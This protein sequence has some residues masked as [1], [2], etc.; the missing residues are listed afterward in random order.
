M[1]ARAASEGE[2]TSESLAHFRLARALVAAGDDRVR[3]IG[4]AE[5]ARDGLRRS[6]QARELAEVE[7]WLAAERG[8]RR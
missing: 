1:T 3:A 8:R 4:A 7:S 6:G 2:Q 5:R